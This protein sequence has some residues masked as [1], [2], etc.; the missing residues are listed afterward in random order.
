VK[1]ALTM[2]DQKFPGLANRGLYD[3]KDPMGIVVDYLHDIERQV[4]TNIDLVTTGP[5]K[6]TW[7]TR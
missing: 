4:G 6:A 2:L 7:V 5:N 1:V 3:E